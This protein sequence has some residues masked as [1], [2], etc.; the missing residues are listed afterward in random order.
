MLCREVAYDKLKYPFP[1][2]FFVEAKERAV[3]EELGLTGNEA[4]VYAA[5]CRAGQAIA[6]DISRES[7]VY[8]T[9][10]YDALDRLTE[11]GLVSQITIGNKKYFE[12]VEPEELMN[13]FDMQEQRIRAELEAFI[14]KLEAEYRR[15]V[16]PTVRLFYGAEGIKSVYLDELRT[17]PAGENVLIFHSINAKQVL[18]WFVDYWHKQRT[19]KGIGLRLI[20]DKKTVGIQR[21]A[22]LS[23]L[24]GSELRVTQED[25]STP[26]SYHIYGDKV[27]ILSYVPGEMI[28]TLIEAPGVAKGFRENFELVWRKLKPF[29]A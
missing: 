15:E 21:L 26:V 4:K 6:N 19:K 24:P 16:R 2:G 17:I 7:G 28:T 8:R 13:W 18:G 12:A 10:V 1:H 9:L 25:Y 20:L 14:P 27:A 5:M 23:K 3:L 11:R 29:K 22:L